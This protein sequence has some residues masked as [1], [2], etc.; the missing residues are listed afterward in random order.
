M[1]NC[2][3]Y[4]HKSIFSCGGRICSV[5]DIYTPVSSLIRIQAAKE[6]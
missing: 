1:L 3:K 5:M 2:Y 6:V 4:M